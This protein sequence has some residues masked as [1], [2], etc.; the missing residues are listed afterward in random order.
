MNPFLSRLIAQNILRKK[1][2]EH[3]SGEDAREV[4]EFFISFKRNTKDILSLILGV[5]SAGFGL[6]GFLLPNNFI[7]GGA[8]GISLLLSEILHIDLSYLL[9]IINIPFIILAGNV[10]NKTFALKTII[11]I[12]SL[13]VVVHFIPFP[14]ITNDKLLISIFGGFFLGAGIGLAIRGGAVLDGT[15]ILAIYVGRKFTIAIGDVIMM[16]NVIIFAFAAYLLG[17]ETAMYALLTYLSATKTVDFLIEGIEEYFA[18]TIISEHSY[19]IQR[20]IK[21]KMKRGYTVYL[22]KKGTG[23]TGEK[24]W[25]AE[26]VYTVITRLEIGKLYSEIEKIDSDAFIVSQSVKD[27]R[28][29]MVKKRPIDVIHD[30]SQ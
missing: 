13:A 20:M 18:I 9:V 21:E 1:Q 14:Q 23:K 16:L 19:D 24:N 7:D 11:A 28:G 2:G 10:I 30:E 5:I 26:I 25:E 12:I 15:E 3:S 6:R 29:G 22:Q 27:I 4:N 8:T 17:I